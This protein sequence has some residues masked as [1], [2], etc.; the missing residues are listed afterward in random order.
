MTAKKTLILFDQVI[1]SG[2]NFIFSILIARH[3]GVDLLGQYAAFMI[4]VLFFSSIINAF[5]ISPLLSTYHSI[6]SDKVNDYVHGFNTNCFIFI[7]LISVI[8]I[9][10]NLLFCYFESDYLMIFPLSYLLVE[11]IRKLALLKEDYLN[12]LI[13]SCIAYLGG[14]ISLFLLLQYREASIETLVSIQIV[15]FSLAI[16]YYALVSKNYVLTRK[17]NNI[18]YSAKVSYDNGR[19]LFLTTFTQ[20]FGE[21][22]VLLLTSALLGSFALGI[23]RIVQNLIGLMNV[24]IQLLDNYTVIYFA[25][26]YNYKKEKSSIYVLIK[27]LTSITISIGV[28]FFLFMYLFGYEIV[29]FIYGSLDE[30][31]LNIT[32]LILSYVI[33]Y[34]VQFL[35]LYERA[36]LKVSQETILILKATLVSMF[37]TIILSYPIV[38][39]FEVFGSVG[40]ILL[41]WCVVYIY[42][43]LNRGR[44]E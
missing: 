14:F 8:S 25:K 22:F 23:L 10:Y 24:I 43:I 19:W 28:L 12:M 37:I 9:L 15:S 26:I 40:L 27:K 6:P 21:P 5:F 44:G 11:Y 38:S 35:V 41:N 33:I 2:S 34:I 7:V 36:W 31:K 42:L 1:V 13:V 30:N 39:K 4:A 29:G 32:F 17:W 3:L 20:W 18:K 16:V